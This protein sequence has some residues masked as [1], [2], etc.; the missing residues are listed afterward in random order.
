MIESKFPAKRFFTLFLPLAALLVFILFPFYWTL[1][2]SLKPEAE[3]YGAV[4][5][6][7]KTVIFDAY[8]KLFTTTVNFLAAMKNSLI[9]ASFTRMVSL[10]VLPL[11]RK[12]SPSTLSSFCRT[13]DATAAELSM[14]RIF[15]RRSLQSV[16]W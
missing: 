3:L 6:W 9:V 1:I 10:C 16:R 13:T 4:T 11:S 2:T 5:Y 8:V 7:P 12:Y 15:K 14:A